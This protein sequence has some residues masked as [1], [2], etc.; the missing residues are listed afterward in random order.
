M[1]F[2]NMGYSDFC[3]SKFHI[4]FRQLSSW[5]L[6]GIS[7]L[8]LSSE[9]YLPSAAKLRQGNVFRSVCQEFCPHWGGC[10][11]QC[12][13][14][15]THPPTRRRLLQRT[16]RILLECILVFGCFRD[17]F[18]EMD[19]LWSAAMPKT[20]DFLFFFLKDYYDKMLQFHI[21]LWQQ[22]TSFKVPT[23]KRRPTVLTHI[24]WGRKAGQRCVN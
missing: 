10:L 6:K 20:N 15:Y 19:N 24:D 16:V 5:F 11:P 22:R 7:F 21:E 1:S 3:H 12:M 9:T 8:P 2:A 18:L 23:S 14:G 13:L 17:R 4:R